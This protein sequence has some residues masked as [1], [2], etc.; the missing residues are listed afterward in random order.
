MRLALISD[1]HA[2]DVAFRAVAEDIDFQIVDPQ[3]FFVPDWSSAQERPDS[4]EEL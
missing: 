4:R 1:Q 3:I 2:N